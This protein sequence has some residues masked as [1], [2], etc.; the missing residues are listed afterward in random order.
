MPN[1]SFRFSLVGIIAAVALAAF[2][3]PASAEIR[4]IQKSAPTSM[5]SHEGQS[6][7]ASALLKTPSADK[8]TE[9]PADPREKNAKKV[10]KLIKGTIMFIRKGDMSIEYAEN[11]ALGG[12]E[13]NLAIDPKVKLRNVK[14]F[15]QFKRGDEVQAKY[16]QVYLEPE[17]AGGEPYVLRS[18]VTELNLVKAAVPAPKLEDKGASDG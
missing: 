16:T 13:M 1:K 17:K 12:Q 14:N 2:V 3:R 8:K 6:A 9:V 11:D 7:P 5:V 18:V 10:E 15:A 4:L